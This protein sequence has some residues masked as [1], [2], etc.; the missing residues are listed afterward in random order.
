MI[1]K[2]YKDELLYL[3]ELGQEFALAHPALAHNLSGSGHDP[4]V[5]RMLEGF[6]F[7]SAR[8]RQ[9][10]DDEFPE[11]VHGVMQLMWPHYLRPVPSMSILEFV[12]TL[13]ALRQSQSVPRGTEVQSV[14]VDGTPCRFR[15][16]YDVTLH[17]LSLETAALETRTTGRS[18]L[19]LEFRLWNQARPEALA[20]DSLRL[21]LHGDAAVSFTL[22]HHLCA[23]L[24]TAQVAVPGA[25]AS[26]RPV[27]VVP[28]GFAEDEALLPYAATS[29]PAYRHLQEYFALPQKF[30]FVELQGLDRL[31]E[32]PVS[33]RFEVD[34]QFDQALPA[35][36]RVSRDNLRLYCTPIVNLFPVDGDPIRLDRSQSEY[37]LR[38]SGRDPLHSEVHTVERVTA[39][40][41][42]K[43][44]P[45]EVPNFYAFT[46]GMGRSESCYYSARLRSSVVDQR[47][48]L[49]ISFVDAGS[50]PAFPDA[51]TVSFALTC[52]NR[53]LAEGL[54]IGDIKIPS[55]NSP[56][57]V[58]FRNLTVPTRSAAPP[59]GG[60]LHWRLVS[61]L[62]LNHLPVAS[63]EALRGVLDLYNFQVIHDAQAARANALRLAGLQSVR[64]EAD[65]ALIGGYLMRGTVVTIEVLE[66]HFA[67]EGDLYL[68]A[69]VLQEY[70]VLHATL[71]AYVEVRVRGIQRG[72]VFAWPPRIGRDRL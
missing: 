6:A 23:H 24:E 33:D 13:Q 52:T 7:L 61:H 51:E 31:R 3:R 39:L 21:Y 71:N 2:Y 41:S 10:L 70:I 45:R 17:P 4:D 8:V 54:E 38:P 11:L 12:P 72:Q 63:V 56:P 35:S 1:E 48:D 66:D 26:A 16:A 25:A 30:L 15:T 18:R 14:P 64:A 50:A 37:R 69:T 34:L 27:R 9:K 42:G 65:V 58:Q 40:V 43:A 68:F 55:D 20:L 49:Y 62:T 32:L 19:R 22:Y 57:F 29:F 5:E 36:L 59:L 46:S 53:R 60:D 44:E 28:V 67:S 47:P